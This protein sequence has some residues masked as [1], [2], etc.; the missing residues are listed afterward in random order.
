MCVDA[1]I[2]PALF[3]LTH[4]PSTVLLP[5]ARTNERLALLLSFRCLDAEKR[6]YIN[7]NQFGDLMRHIRPELFDPASGYVACTQALDFFILCRA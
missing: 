6:G 4:L 3:T 1:P 5:Q 2:T 7:L